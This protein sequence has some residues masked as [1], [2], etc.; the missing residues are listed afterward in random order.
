MLEA[1]K[2]L[3]P[4]IGFFNVTDNEFSTFGRVINGLDIKELLGAAKKIKKP[5]SGSS[6]LPSVE[7]FEKLEIATLFKNKFYGSLPAQVGYCWGHNT[8]MNAT[9]WHSANEI[10]VAVTPLILILGHLWDIENGKIDSSKF[11]A[12]YLPEG[13]VAEIYATTLHFC[14]CEV[15]KEGFGCVVGLPKDTNTN[16]SEKPLTPVLF[17]KNK[18]LLAHIANDVLINKGAVAGIT[19]TNF[20]I[21]Y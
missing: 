11:K 10:N 21:K 20:K 13:T 2:K 1:L 9:E 5:E 15:D 19:G 6:Y 18:W 16:L 8:L 17:R 12:F 7:D 14:P 4:E 3:N